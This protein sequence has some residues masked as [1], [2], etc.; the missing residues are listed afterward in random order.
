MFWDKLKPTEAPP[1]AE[2]VDVEGETIA[3]RWADGKRSEVPARRLRLDCPCAACID[4]WT[5]APLL[6][7]QRVPADVRP[8]AMEAVGNYAVQ[9]RWSDGHETGIYTWRQLRSYA[10]GEAAWAPRRTR[11]SE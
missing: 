9:I 3:V 1:R 8:V 2:A 5:G 11:A 7:P 4:E 10:P 6:D